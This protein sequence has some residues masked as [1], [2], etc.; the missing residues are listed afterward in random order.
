[1]P[2]PH[3]A[4]DDAVAEVVPV[5]VVDIDPVPHGAADVDDDAIA[6]VSAPMGPV[7]GRLFGTGC[8]V[9]PTTIEFSR[10]LSLALHSGQVTAKR[11][12]LDSIALRFGRNGYRSHNQ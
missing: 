11:G 9:E 8:L 7:P 4:A 1:M 6:S 10:T 2:V 5:P 12:V 3:G